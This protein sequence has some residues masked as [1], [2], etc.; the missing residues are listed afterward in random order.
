MDAGLH[1]LTASRY[2]SDPAPVPSLSSSVAKT[3]ITQS[4]LHAMLQHPRLNPN[5]APEYD[6]T[7]DL[8][9]A[10]HAMLLERDGSRIV[11]CEYDD[12]R[13]KAARSVRESVREAGKLPL[14]VKYRLT[15]EAMVKAARAAV[16]KSELQDILDTG[17]PE[18][19]ILWEEKGCWCRSRLDLLSKDRSVILDYK[20]TTNAEPEHFIRQIERMSYDLQAEFYT[21]GVD[22]ISGAVRP[23]PR[24]V[25]LA[26]EV[27]PPY[28]CSL[29]A[30]SNAYRA[31]G[32][33]KVERALLLWAECMKKQ[34]WPSYTNQICYAEP[35]PWVLAGVQSEDGAEM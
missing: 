6:G 29:I 31:V 11:W 25:F 1:D 26:Q 5:Y 4:P 27:T 18:Q 14:L 24:F 34:Q 22:K 3:L 12:W 20:S 13:T 19:S 23:K 17:K 7:F 28:A 33:A 15:L 30:L 16:E 8:G 2:H 21:R 9:T 32:Q 35:P 10:A